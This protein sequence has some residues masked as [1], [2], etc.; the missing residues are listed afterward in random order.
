MI[1]KLKKSDRERFKDR[2]SKNHKDNAK[3]QWTKSDSLE[4]AIKDSHA[5]IFL[6]E[7]DEFKN[8]NLEF[9]IKIMKKPSW[10]FDTRLLV[11]I[12]KS[13]KSRIPSLANRK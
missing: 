13:S 7:W 12:E 1:Q 4:N 6:T 2:P 8:I 9:L 11:N 5:I 3:V 10:I